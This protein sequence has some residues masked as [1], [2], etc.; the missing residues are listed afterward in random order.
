MNKLKNIYCKDNISFIKPFL[1]SS[2]ITRLKDIGMHCGLEYTSFPF[3]SKLKKYSRYTHSL[4]V[5]LI[6]Y[7]FT[8]DIKMSLSGLFHDISTGCFSH[9]I[10]FVYNDYLKQEY[11]E[12]KTEEFILQD[13]VIMSNLNKLNIKVSEVS[14][15]HLY[16]IADNNTPKL[17]SDRLEYTLS[18]FINFNFLNINKIKEIYDDLV[19]DKNEDN[20]DEIVF[21]DI[22]LAKIFTLNMLKNSKAYVSDEDRYSMERLSL[23]LKYALKN[24]IINEADFYLKETKMINKLKK[25][26]FTKKMFLDFTSLHKV[27]ISNIKKDD[28]YIKIFAK[29]RY[30]DPYIKNK[31]R[32]SKLDKDIKNQ[33]D[34]FVNQSQDYFIKGYSI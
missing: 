20:E 26:S 4:N 27:E 32:L 23:I 19:V 24:N 6:I 18:N 14:N 21:Q 1:K 9:V 31:G 15:Y 29:K 22:E 16:T 2:S 12:N 5:A 30:I 13:K 11:S 8:K 33:I 28:N 25:D 3:Y 10:D 34:D 7:N 17:S